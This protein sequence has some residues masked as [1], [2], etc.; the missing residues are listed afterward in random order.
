[1]SVSNSDDVMLPILATAER[2]LFSG[3]T[4]TIVMPDDSEEFHDEE[5][6]AGP[7]RPDPDLDVILEV[8]KAIYLLHV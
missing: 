3:G 5:A 2:R 1:M 4:H 6:V 8:Y 7:A